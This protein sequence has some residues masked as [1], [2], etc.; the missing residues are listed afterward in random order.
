MPPS[1]TVALGRRPSHLLS[2]GAGNGLRV[3]EEGEVIPGRL[4][5]GGAHEQPLEDGKALEEE[6]PHRRRGLGPAPREAHF[7]GADCLQLLP[8]L[9]SRR[10]GLGERQDTGRSNRV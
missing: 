2:G 10:L 6:P 7:D 8:S 5:G 3:T 1:G 4:P 9:E